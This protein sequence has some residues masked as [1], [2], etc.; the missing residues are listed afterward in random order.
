MSVDHFDMSEEF[1]G[2]PMSDLIGGPLQAA[3]DAQIKLSKEIE[4]RDQVISDTR[5]LPDSL[6]Q[7]NGNEHS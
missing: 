2:L 3:C 5:P 1:R 7:H 4:N 6:E